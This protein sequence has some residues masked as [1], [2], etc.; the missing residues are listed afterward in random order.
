MPLL[1]KLQLPAAAVTQPALAPE[2]VRDGLRFELSLAMDFILFSLALA[3]LVALGHT[4]AILTPTIVCYLTW[5]VLTTAPASSRARVTAALTDVTVYVY[6]AFL[7]SLALTHPPIALE[8]R[9][10]FTIFAF[11]N[12]VNKL[13]FHPTFRQLIHVPLSHT[14]VQTG[15]GLLFFITAT[16]I[17]TAPN[18]TSVWG[19]DCLWYSSLALLVCV[20]CVTLAFA[21]QAAVTNTT[22][23]RLY[24]VH[25]PVIDV[26]WSIRSVVEFRASTGLKLSAFLRLLESH[27][28][29][30]G[31]A[32]LDCHTCTDLLGDDRGVSVW[33]FLSHWKV[34]RLGKE[35]LE[36]IEKRSKHVTNP[37]TWSDRLEP[38]MRSPLLRGY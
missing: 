30:S 23:T 24:Q 13:K 10:M 20:S 25:S 32:L 17:I 33:Q 3:V 2:E 16:Y 26:Y 15:V 4:N 5:H 9:S 19:R 37:I 38:P 31:E 11:A 29:D 7:L 28:R 1:D 22:T 34:A 27:I 12:V 36:I 8:I 14:T 35:N 21:S 18:I 6:A